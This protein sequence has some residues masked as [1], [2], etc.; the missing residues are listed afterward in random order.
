MH[1][2]YM[3]NPKPG[4]K[5]GDHVRVK[6]LTAIMAT[7]DA[8]NSLD[9]MP[10]MPEM[11]RFC[12]QRMQVYRRA[13]KTCDTIDGS[14]GRRLVGGGTVHLR[15]AR[16]DGSAHGGCEALCLLFWKEA[17]L[18]PDERCAPGASGNA[19]DDSPAMET[20]L[21]STLVSE[22]PPTYSC[23]ATQLKAATLPLRWWD[24]RQYLLDLRSGNANVLQVIW[25][26]SY[27]AY[28]SLVGLGVAHRYL[29]AAYDLYQKLVGGTHWPLRPGSAQG[30][31]P[32][33]ELNLKPGDWVRVRPYEEI[34]TTLDS[35]S[36]NRGLW[37][38]AEMVPYCGGT[39]RVRKQVKKILNEKTGQMMEMKTPCLIL[40]DVYCRSR[41]SQY[42]L[43]CPRA[44]YSYWRE[45]WL[46]P[47]DELDAN[48]TVGATLPTHERAP[49]VTKTNDG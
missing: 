22:S 18:E 46:E 30:R 43:F 13:D 17:W 36:K 47:I 42:R 16:C 6:P 4:L 11:S 45:I 14:G 39:Y 27:S 3:N 26:A 10:F 7:L 38:D 29:V 8:E 33:A 31:T 5:R 23:Q 12:G 37:F 35:N 49:A 24:L 21:A 15:G 28:R 1:R 48:A 32:V 25:A 40:E 19:P 34:L 20:L 44:I 2:P 41:Y 9:G